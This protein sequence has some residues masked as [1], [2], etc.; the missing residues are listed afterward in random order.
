MKPL[1]KFVLT[2]LL[3]G[4]ALLGTGCLESDSKPYGSSH[5]FGENNRDVY[6][7]I[8]DSMT[9]SVYGVTPY[10]EFLANMLDKTVINEGVG[11]ERVPDGA[12]RTAEVLN[13]HRPGYLLIM[14]GINDV[15]T[16][17]PLAA[18]SVETQK[19]LRAPWLR[20]AARVDSVL[21][22]LTSTMRIRVKGSFS[23]RTCLR[24]ERLRT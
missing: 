6:V 2:A 18:L 7:C 15:E 10:P 3:G 17:S 23:L 13:R 4:I 5:D 22:I 1:S 14:H 11:G 16:Q 24:A 21:R 20:A 19:Y 12:A 9:R 8:G